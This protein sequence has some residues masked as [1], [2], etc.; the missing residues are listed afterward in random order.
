MMGLEGIVLKRSNLQTVR[1]VAELVECRGP[2]KRPPLDYGAFFAK[3][4]LAN[5]EA[6]CLLWPVVEA[7]PVVLGMLGVPASRSRTSFLAASQH[8]KLLSDSPGL[9]AD[10]AT[11]GAVASARSAAPANREISS[12][13]LLSFDRHQ[14]RYK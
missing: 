13:E 8:L 6:C 1:L 10:C 7:L 11:A 14:C 9:D 5:R 2:K 3:R 12:S 4:C